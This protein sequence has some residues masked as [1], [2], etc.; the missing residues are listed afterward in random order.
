MLK[1][2]NWCQLLWQKQ[3]PCQY[4]AS[5]QAKYTSVIL[6]YRKVFFTPGFNT[7]PLKTR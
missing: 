4:K 6:P 3:S 7:V 1:Y 5:I 2:I